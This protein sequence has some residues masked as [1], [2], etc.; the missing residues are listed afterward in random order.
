MKRN[1]VTKLMGMSFAMTLAFSSMTVCAADSIY[2]TQKGDNLSRIAQKVYGDKMRW[3]DIYE[4][5]KDVIKDPNAIWVNQQLVIPDAVIDN[6]QPTVPET[7]SIPNT[8][9]V[10][11]TPSIP[12]EVS[13]EWQAAGLSYVEQNGLS[14]YQ[15]T[16]YPTQGYVSVESNPEEFEFI[17]A[18]GT[19]NSISICDANKEGYQIVTISNSTSG[20]WTATAGEYY[21]MITLPGVAL[22]DIYTGQIFPDASTYG[23]VELVNT[24]ILNW[25]EQSYPIDYIQDV[26]WV[27]SEWIE[28]DED[29][30]YKI[31]TYNQ[32]WTVA[33][34]KG[35]DG[36]ALRTG[37]LTEAPNS[38]E[39]YNTFDNDTVEYIMDEWKDGRYL[40]RVSD[41]YNILNG[42]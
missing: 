5:N 29:E 27:D 14:F 21:D 37:I 19:I 25:G 8:P 42:Q 33:I 17:S 40:I 41:L 12:W 24:T 18:D 31:K 36:L 23:D 26:N 16:S 2:T 35:Y 28:P 15:G 10:P 13:P 9:S 7:P 4:A 39:E 38:D 22:C 20:L 1:K 3:K 32:A 34:P 30:P 6:T 11:S